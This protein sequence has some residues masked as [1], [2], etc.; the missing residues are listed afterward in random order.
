MES[1]F[2]LFY[3]DTVGGLMIVYMIFMHCCQFTG[4]T[5]TFFF[6]K[7]SIVFNCFMAW[8]FFKSGMFHKAN[9]AVRDAAKHALQK[10]LRPYLAFMIIGFVFYCVFLYLQ[11]DMNWIHYTLSPIKV[12]LVNGAHAWALPLWFLV[13]LFLVKSLSPLCVYNFSR[14]GWIYAVVGLIAA[15]VSAHFFELRPYYLVNIFPAMSFYGLGYVLKEKQFHKGLFLCSIVVLI[16]SFVCPVGGD[17]RTNQTAGSYL[18]WLLYEFAGIVCFNNIFKKV[19]IQIF[20]FTQIGEHS[21]YWF[22]AHWFLL[23]IIS[24]TM[25]LLGMEMQGVKSL[26]LVFSILMILLTT[27]FPVVYYTRLRKF[28]GL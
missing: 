15:Y 10:L 8:F 16:F 3:L 18:L 5:D 7:F 19:H 25:R 26:I 24:S 2:R 9:L 11:G 20:P 4:M 17:F 1:K 12:S 22:L 13:T 23:Q 21:M 14:W 28:V 6:R 27:L